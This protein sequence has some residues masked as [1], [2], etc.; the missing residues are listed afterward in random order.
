[1]TQSCPVGRVAGFDRARKLLVL[2]TPSRAALIAT[3]WN[4]NTIL[5]CSTCLDA[6]TSIAVFSQKVLCA[7]ATL[8]GVAK[9]DP[10]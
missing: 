7:A 10:L 1:M 6:H 5:R 3:P 8:N 4:G 9:Y 2:Y